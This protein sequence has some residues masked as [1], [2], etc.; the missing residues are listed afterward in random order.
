MT[1]ISKKFTFLFLLVYEFL[2]ALIKT[3][4]NNPRR[5]S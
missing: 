3:K 1:K 2:N 5:P 4:P